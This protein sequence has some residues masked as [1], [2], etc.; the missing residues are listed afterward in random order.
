MSNKYKNIV[1]KANSGDVHFQSPRALIA[2]FPY[3]KR[4]IDNISAVKNKDKIINLN[5]YLELRS[6]PIS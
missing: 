4:K 5:D 3:R 1:L 2:I 6:Q